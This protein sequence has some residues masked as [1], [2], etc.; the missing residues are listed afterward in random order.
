MN[1]DQIKEVLH[2]HE[3]W[4]AAKP[5]GKRADL[6]GADLHGANLYGANLHGA[7]LCDADLSGANLC[8]ANLYGANL[9]RADLY[10]ANLS[11][12]NLSGANLSGANLYGANL[13]GANL[14]GAVI[15]DGV[16]VNRLIALAT[17]FCD[18]YE[19]FLFETESGDLFGFFGC[20]AM[21]LDDFEKHV[22][23]YADNDPRK[24]QSEDIIAY[25]RAAAARAQN[26]EAA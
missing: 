22:E 25:F 21:S 24:G 12:A 20:R 14:C 1:A 9:S 17:R 10:G 19:G 18:G 2:L 3:L 26:E 8:R 5:G 16:T 23:A 11:R 4:L 7:H 13:S 15:A 6:H